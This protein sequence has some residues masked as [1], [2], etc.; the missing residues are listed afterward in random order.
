[1]FPTRYLCCQPEMPIRVLKKFV[2]YKFD[3]SSDLFNV[4]IYYFYFYLY[5]FFYVCKSVLLIF[6]S[7]LNPGILYLNQ[8][9][10]AWG[11]PPPLLFSHKTVLFSH[12]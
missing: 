5:M 3:I 10:G 9:R 4:H 1:M 6:Y 7:T 12:K 2:K 8:G 11:E